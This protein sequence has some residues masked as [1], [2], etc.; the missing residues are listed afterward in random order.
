MTSP[1]QGSSLS[2]TIWSP[3]P[4]SLCMS[5]QLKRLGSCLVPFPAETTPRPLGKKG[6]GLSASLASSHPCR[7][8]RTPLPPH[9]QLG[10]A[11]QS[12]GSAPWQA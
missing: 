5:L 12:Q 6:S 4:V 2:S 11:H 3:H 9:R 1:V 10:H 7:T 8:D